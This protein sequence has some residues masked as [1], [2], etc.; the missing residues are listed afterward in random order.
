[1]M[2]AL[3]TSKTSVLIRTTRRNIPEDG[4]LHSHCRDKLKS[5]TVRT[6]TSGTY[7]AELMNW[8]GGYRPGNDLA[9]DENGEL[10]A[11]SYN[12]FNRWKSY[13]SHLLSAHNASDVGQIEIHTAESIVP[14]P[15]HLEDD[16]G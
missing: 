5:Y 1:M 4:I 9:K 13:F 16:T 11:D 8:G 3:Y 12:S 2:E 15:S 10:L 6:R 14:G 7:M